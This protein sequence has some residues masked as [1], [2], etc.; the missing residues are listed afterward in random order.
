MRR[1]IEASK[2]SLALPLEARRTH[3]SDTYRRWYDGLG[4]MKRSGAAL[5]QDQYALGL[6]DEGWLGMGDV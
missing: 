4:F 5:R 3:F 2:S 6:A 1:E